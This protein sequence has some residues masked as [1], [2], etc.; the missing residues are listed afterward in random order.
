MKPDEWALLVV[1]VGALYGVSLVSPE[2]AAM[3]GAFTGLV[4]LVESGAF[5]RLTAL[6]G[7]NA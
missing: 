7:G 6:I 1:F 3:L 4:L 2:A 5:N